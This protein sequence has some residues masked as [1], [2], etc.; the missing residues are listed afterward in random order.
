MW[1]RWKCISIPYSLMCII[2]RGSENR[3][4]GTGRFQLVHIL[5]SSVS[6]F[7]TAGPGYQQQPSHLHQMHKQNLQGWV[8]PSPLWTH[9]S[10][11]ICQ[12]WLILWLAPAAPSM[13]KNLMPII[14][15]YFLI[16][17]VVPLP[18]LNPDLYTQ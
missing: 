16:L 5:P 11:W 17:T 4:K 8:H 12:G 6:S 1:S 18:W 10:S 15:S 14:T 9:S 13:M 7:L 3:G 2:I